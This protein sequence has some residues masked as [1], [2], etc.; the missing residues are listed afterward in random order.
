MNKRIA[1]YT[2][3]N[4][5]LQLE[6]LFL[7][8]ED[9]RLLM[10]KR[11]SKF[12]PQFVPSCVTWGIHITCSTLLYNVPKSFNLSRVQRIQNY[13]T[14]IFWNYLI[15]RKTLGYITLRLLNCFKTVF[16]ML[17]RIYLFVLK[18]RQET[19]AWDT[20]N[21][22]QLI[23]ILSEIKQTIP[24]CHLATLLPIFFVLL[25]VSLMK[26]NTIHLFDNSTYTLNVA[27]IN[28]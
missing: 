28:K 20:N 10:S 23:F 3:P 17:N 12:T 5:L 1:S 6:Y 21:S 9:W 19:Q 24:E 11:C 15:H 26:H 14:K 7:V 22:Y 25:N 13:L 27:K 4:D 2:Y 18:R 8:E 16:D